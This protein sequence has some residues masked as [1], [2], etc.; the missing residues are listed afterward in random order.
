MNFNFN[1]FNFNKIVYF[2]AIIEF[3]FTKINQ[4]FSI[5]F[6]NYLREKMKEIL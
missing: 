4:I 5:N 1:A 3:K 6:I 2:S